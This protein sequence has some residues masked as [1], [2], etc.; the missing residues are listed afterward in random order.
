M[1]VKMTIS[2][3]GS[4]FYGFQVQN[5]GVETVANRLSSIFRSLGIDSK[6]EASGRTDR[7]VHAT[8]QVLSLDLPPYWHDLSR[9]RRAFNHKALPHIYA[10]SIEAAPADFHARYDAK[11]RA[12]RYLVSQGEPCVFHTPYLLYTRPF[13][14]R[15]IAEVIRRFEGTH[16]FALFAKTGSDVTHYVRTVYRAR[17]YRHGDLF[18]FGFEADGYVRSQIRLM[19]AFLLRIGY[20]EMEASQLEEQ[21]GGRERFVSEP[22]APNGLYLTRIWY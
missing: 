15:R 2:Y 21:L 20:G 22:I 12:Y 19:V 18:I 17:F 16:D 7:G 9:L 3:D 4:R 5:S 13:D 10:R 11:K 8:G 1:R 14:P 6:F